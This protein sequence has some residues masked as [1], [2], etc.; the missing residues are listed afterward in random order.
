MSG[1]SI[2]LLS[3]HDARAAHQAI[4]NALEAQSFVCPVEG[5]Y[6]SAVAIPQRFRELVVIANMETVSDDDRTYLAGEPYHQVEEMSRNHKTASWAGQVIFR[7]ALSASSGEL[8]LSRIQASDRAESYFLV[9]R[10]SQFA[11]IL[12]KKFIA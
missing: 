7:S 9:G 3:T 10:K 4:K 2:A 5:N 6:R 1:M 11:I 8:S 12:T